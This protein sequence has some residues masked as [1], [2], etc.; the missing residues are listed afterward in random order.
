MIRTMGVIRNLLSRDVV[1]TFR[2]A[3]GR[4]ESELNEHLESINANT[5]EI[6]SVYELL[7]ELDAKVEKLASRIDDLQVHLDVPQRKVNVQIHPLTEKEKEIFFALYT[8]DNLTYL[9]IA[10]KTG[11]DEVMVQDYLTNLIAKGI[12][13]LKRYQNEK[14][15]I[16][17]ERNFKEI[18]A[19][20][21]IVKH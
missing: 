12:P 16:S 14:I 6:Q 3:F 9:D 13:I 18:Q 1:K 8:E 4:V 19:K 21:N 11:Y 20:E 15:C 10:R 17:L 5:S 7:N 2:M